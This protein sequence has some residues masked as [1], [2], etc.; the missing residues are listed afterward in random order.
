[1]EFFSQCIFS[2][3]YFEIISNWQK[4]SE[5]SIKNSLP[6]FAHTQWLL[7][8]CHIG[9]IS[10]SFHLNDPIYTWTFVSQSQSILKPWNLLPL[11]SNTYRQWPNQGT[12]RKMTVDGKPKTTSSAC[13]SSGC[14][15]PGCNL[16]L[17]SVDGI[18][19][20]SR[21]G[22][23]DVCVSCFYK[24][25]AAALLPELVRALCSLGLRLAVQSPWPLR[26]PWCGPHSHPPTAERK[27]RHGALGTGCLSCL[28]PLPLCLEVGS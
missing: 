19:P 1:M 28:R 25:L 6:A 12:G 13:C 4:S 10:L 15:S 22:I 17:F 21:D 18:V 20:G 14:V 9:F 3:L 16:V 7:P 5:N 24:Q 2:N 23:Q 8:S 27:A 11:A 26:T